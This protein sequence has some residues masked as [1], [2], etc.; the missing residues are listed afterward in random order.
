MKLS[1]QTAVEKG[2]WQ[3]ERNFG[4]MLMLIVSE[5]GEALE[6]HRKGN[7]FGK[8]GVTEELADVFIRLG[9]L[10]EGVPELNNIENAIKT[11]M[12]FNKTRPKKHGKAY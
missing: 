1:H 5:L 2:F 7:W 4:E 12:E 8:D 6:A 9:D 3:E 10:C 11:K